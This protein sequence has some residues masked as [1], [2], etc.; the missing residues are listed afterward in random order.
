MHLKA[1]TNKEK[2]TFGSLKTAPDE[3]VMFMIQ[4]ETHFSENFQTLLIMP[5]VGAN[6]K[7]YFSKIPFAHPCPD[8]PIDYL[9]SLFTRMKIYFTLKFANREFKTQKTN[10]TP[11]KLT[12]LQN[13]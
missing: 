1:F 2:D 11:I 5:N 12:I 7:Y 4:L 13:Q 9:V 6:L 3:F 10:K 8:F